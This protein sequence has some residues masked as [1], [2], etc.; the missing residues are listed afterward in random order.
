[1]AR[2]SFA[3]GSM[4]ETKCFWPLVWRGRGWGRGVPIA[5]MRIV[6]VIFF[7]FVLAR[8]DGETRG[9]TPLGVK[10][11]VGSLPP[12]REGEAGNWGKPFRNKDL[13]CHQ[14]TNSRG[15]RELGFWHSWIVSKRE[16]DSVVSS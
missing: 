10:R 9:L 5:L 12:F 2:H 8:V 4:L 11:P 1:M 14:N 6:R 3:L 13:F 15:R 7:R 16:V